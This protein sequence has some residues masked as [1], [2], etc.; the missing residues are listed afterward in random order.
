MPVSFSRFAAT[1][2]LPAL[3]ALTALAACSTTPQPKFQQELFDTGSSPYTHNF[4][5][6]TADTCEGARRAL[7][8]QGYMTTMTRTDTVDGTKN[9]QPNGD[10][11]IVVEFHVVCTAGV[12][13]GN[14]S[15]VYVNAVQN[16]Y[17]LKK[18]DTSASVGLSILGSVSL[19]IRSNN[20]EMVK[21]SSETIPSG[22]FYDRFFALV[23]HYVETVVHA[24]PVSSERIDA[25]PLPG[26]DLPGVPLAPVMPSVPAT[27]GTPGAP[28]TSPAPLTP[29][30]S[31]A[32]LAP[33]KPA[34]PVVPAVPIASALPAKPAAA[35]APDA[36]NTPTAPDPIER[37]IQAA[38]PASAAAA[39]T[40]P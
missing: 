6:S 17:A 15:V 28:V 7:L 2:V 10:S 25:R 38:Q 39:S 27:S 3:T 19:P 13:A 1:R 18:S 20:D 34:M 4:N 29:L 40:A 9:F 32:P 16:G 33:P 31:L 35:T 36:L 30:P 11:H 21:V 26:G 8:S 23:G 24:A 22:Q 37:A 12:E 5:A 14:T